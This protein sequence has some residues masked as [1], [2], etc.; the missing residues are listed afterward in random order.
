MKKHD[1]P[2]IVEQSFNAPIERVWNAITD[3][4]QMRQWY[5]DNI[6][7]FKA[8]VGFETQFDVQTE[9]R[10]FR[11]IWKVT[12]VVPQKLIS[13][14]W[15]YEGYPGDSQVMFE[16]FKGNQSTKLR[17]THQIKESFPQDIPEFSRES[18]IEGWKYFIQNSLKEFLDKS[19]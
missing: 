18:G 5:F 12:E 15:K 3:V 6:P 10:I 9:Q 2:I 14:T 11:H 8:E 17:L 1:Q 4:A 7:A 16:L 19:A 13:Y